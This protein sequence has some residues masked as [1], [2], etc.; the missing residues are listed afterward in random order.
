VQPSKVQEPSPLILPR[1]DAPASSFRQKRRHFD[2]VLQVALPK[3]LSLDVQ[4]DKRVPKV[5]WLLQK[6]ERIER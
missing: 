3:K 2:S 4:A 6:E 5:E 1:P